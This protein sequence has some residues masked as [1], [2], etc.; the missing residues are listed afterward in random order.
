MFMASLS[1]PVNIEHLTSQLMNGVLTCIHLT[2]MLC[3]YRLAL[4][5]LLK[6]SMSGYF[7]Q[8]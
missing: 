6:N 1:K 4:K 8:Y 5:T 7:D 2:L 3:L